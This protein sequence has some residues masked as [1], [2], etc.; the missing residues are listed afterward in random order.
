MSPAS[1][2]VVRQGG[3]AAHWRYSVA[4]PVPSGTVQ[5]PEGDCTAF[6]SRAN[7]FLHST[8]W[9][10]A[11]NVR[12]LWR[13]ASC[14]EINKVIEPIACDEHVIKMIL[15]AHADVPLHA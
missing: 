14:R 5:D 7:Y 3:C 13:G 2:D 8:C 6:Q 4:F 15:V 11:K 1:G 10:C 12:I 9:A